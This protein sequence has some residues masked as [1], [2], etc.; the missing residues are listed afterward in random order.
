MKILSIATAALVAVAGLSPTIAV[1][2]HRTVVTRT[3]TRTHTGP[4]DRSHT[5]RA[6]R[7]TF[8]HGHRI[9]TCR[10]VRN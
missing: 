3:V 4:A 6:C 7:T 5:R 8:R 1:A 9:R 2:Q 10:T